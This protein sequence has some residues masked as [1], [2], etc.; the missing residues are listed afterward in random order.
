MAS[1]AFFCRYFLLLNLN[2]FNLDEIHGQSL[3]RGH[4]HLACMS[5]LHI[6]LA[7]FSI[8]TTVL[9]II[10]TVRLIQFRHAPVENAKRDFVT[11]YDHRNTYVNLPM[12]S[13][14]DKTR[15]DHF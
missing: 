3:V 13:V 7:N 9:F 10:S 5:E 4:Y 1:D 15:T 8:I 14:P 2:A 11:M 12:V 6:T